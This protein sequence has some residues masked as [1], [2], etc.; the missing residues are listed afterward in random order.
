MNKMIVCRM[1]DKFR[2]SRC[3]AQYELAEE[4][5]H[6]WTALVGCPGMDPEE[7]HACA[8]VMADAL[9]ANFAPVRFIGIQEGLH[10]VK[11]V[12]FY[13]ATKAFSGYVKNTCIVRE[14]LYQQGYSVPR[15]EEERECKAWQE[16]ALQLQILVGQLSPSLRQV[17]MDSG[18]K[19]G[20]S[21]A[22]ANSGM[23][24]SGSSHPCVE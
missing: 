1:P 6:H 5:A 20:Q 11:P 4:D 23:V 8:A 14:S 19:N 24:V 17:S 22:A 12:A 16:H 2:R 18:S 13:Q 10:T 7:A 15:T 3:G 21:P 9:N